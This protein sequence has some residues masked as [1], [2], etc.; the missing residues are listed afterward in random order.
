VFSEQ[1][2]ELAGASVNPQY[3]Y[4]ELRPTANDYAGPATSNVT[5]ERAL[6]QD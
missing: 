1:L 4:R 2:K 5:L 3:R 6:G